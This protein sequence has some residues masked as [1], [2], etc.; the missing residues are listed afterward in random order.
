MS[1]SWRLTIVAQFLFILGLVGYAL[2]LHAELREIRAN[3]PRIEPLTERIESL[4]T[5]NVEQTQAIELIKKTEEETLANLY[6]EL[7]NRLGEIRNSVNQLK[8]SVDSG[9]GSTQSN[10]AKIAELEK[11][12]GA[13]ASLEK[14]ITEIRAEQDAL[15]TRL[16]EALYAT[17][18]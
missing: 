2:N 15:Q 12:L 5:E 18:Q 10:A 4:E 17:P 11:Q 16:Q 7:E 14:A 13:V 9:N 1:K 8:Q 3:L 6:T